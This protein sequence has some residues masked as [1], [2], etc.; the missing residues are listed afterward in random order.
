MCFGAMRLDA[1]RFGATRCISMRCGFGAKG[2]ILVPCN[3]FWCDA[4]SSILGY[5]ILGAGIDTMQYQGRLDLFT[6]AHWAQK[7][8]PFETG[9]VF[10]YFRCW[11]RHC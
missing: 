4:A 10:W 5:L 11:Y 9:T 7:F 8:G 1:M 2:C 3:L 6:G